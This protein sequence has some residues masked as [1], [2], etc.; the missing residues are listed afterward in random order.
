MSSAHH[1]Y[2]CVALRH[3]SEVSLQLIKLRQDDILEGGPQ[4]QGVGQVIDIFGS[5]REMQVFLQ[6]CQVCILFKLFLEKV[7]YGLHI[8]VGRLL[9]LLDPIAVLDTEVGEYRV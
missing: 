7:L 5:T 8:V 2:I 1:G 3:L 4:H 6:G 9:N